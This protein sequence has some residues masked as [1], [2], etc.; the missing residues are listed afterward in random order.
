M[1]VTSMAISWYT[2]CSTFNF[3]S[4]KAAMGHLDPNFIKQ[5][6]EEF[7]P[8]IFLETGTYNGM[9]ASVASSFFK[10]VHTVELSQPHYREAKALFATSNNVNVY[11]D[12]SPEMIREV[13]PNLDGHILFWLDAHYSGGTTVRGN[14]N[15]NDPDADTAIR[16]ELEVIKECNIQHCTIL[17]DDIRGF[18]TIINDTEY[19]GCWAYPSLQEV[20]R[21]GKEI[22]PNFSFA[23]LGDMLLMHDNTRFNPSFS[24]VVTACTAS[25]LYDG[26]NLSDEELLEYENIIKYAQGDER[27]FIVN[28]Y[29]RM[30]DC[31][32]PL[33]HHDLWYGLISMGS[34]NWG[35][36]LIALE[37]V[38]NRIE[39]LNKYRQNT[40]KCLR[41]NHWR[42][43]H[44]L[45]EVTKRLEAT[46]K[47]E[48]RLDTA[49]SSKS[50][51]SG[52]KSKKSVKK[53]GRSK[54]K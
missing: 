44:Y 13:V 5:L 40:N 20:C 27:T 4:N 34:G 48:S 12:S 21:L 17:I 43:D 49:N 33:F 30:T 31:K 36:A 1:L 25:R 10:Q 3:V 19:L 51:K 38:P 8:D 28:L 15:H 37:K 32:D 54:K 46:K 24:P 35:E 41:Y 6:V 45:L 42:I 53:S 14:D 50:K 2:S 26:T 22:N 11:W 52:R 7:K 9:T 23:L 47:L 16:K 29:R 39:F 18:G